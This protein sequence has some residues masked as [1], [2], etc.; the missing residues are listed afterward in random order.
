MLS[1]RRDTAQEG[2]RDGGEGKEGEGE[3]LVIAGGGVSGVVEEA[4]GEKDGERGEV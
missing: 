1:A 4:G 3:E 2:E